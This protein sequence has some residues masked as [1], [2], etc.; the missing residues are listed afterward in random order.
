MATQMTNIYAKFHYIRFTEYSDIE[1][2]KIDNNG[3]ITDGQRTQCLLPLIGGK[4]IM[5]IILAHHITFAEYEVV[6]K[7][8]QRL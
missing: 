1:S 6:E 7:S 2:H 3:R 5:R 4:V 8:N